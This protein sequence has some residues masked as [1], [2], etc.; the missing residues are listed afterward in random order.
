MSVEP[1][2]RRIWAQAVVVSDQTRGYTK[3]AQIA[4][5]KTDFVDVVSNSGIPPNI[6]KIIETYTSSLFRMTNWAVSE[7]L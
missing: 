1:S 4:L 3:R 7:T 6:F 5:P 2:A